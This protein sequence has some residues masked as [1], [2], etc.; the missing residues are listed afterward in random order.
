MKTLFLLS[1]ILF[2]LS[3]SF[4]LYAS[5]EKLET[6]YQ[7]LVTLFF[8]A[9]RIGNNEVV[10]AFVSQGFPIDQRNNQSYTALMVAA[11]QGNRE[12]VR[13]LLDAG[14]NACLQ[15][16]RG[17]TALMGALIKR[18]VGIARDLYQADCSPELRNK[19]GLNLKEFAEVFG[20]SDVLKSLAK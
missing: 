3:L 10:E 1:S 12:T 2:S 11:Y 14:A 6:E 16:K 5:E 15:D 8:D 18:E 13:Y 20:Q 7:S 17:N 4:S 19:S 9:A